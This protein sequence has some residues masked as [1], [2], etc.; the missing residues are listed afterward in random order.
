MKRMWIGVGLLSLAL[1]AG[2]LAAEWM[3]DTHEE[4]EEN[5][6]QA[7]VFAM[8]EEWEKANALTN[9]A[10]WQ[11][12]KKRPMIAMLADHEPLESIDSLFGQLEIYAACEDRVAFG[13]VCADLSQQLEALG[14]C[15]KCSFSNL[16]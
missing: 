13:A 8:A 10:R 3:E 5:I 1:V 16:L 15:H 9:R 4:M 11:W 12:Q 7:V 2:I 6:Q 14:E